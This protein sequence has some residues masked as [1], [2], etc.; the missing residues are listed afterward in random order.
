M[1]IIRIFD[2]SRANTLRY[3]VYI[4]SAIHN[5]YIFRSLMYDTALL[6]TPTYIRSSPAHTWHPKIR[7]PTRLYTGPLIHGHLLY[8]VCI[9]RAISD[10]IIRCLVF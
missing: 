2:N 7:D 9:L 8:S 6:E 1:H 10:S 5:A 3:V 4:L